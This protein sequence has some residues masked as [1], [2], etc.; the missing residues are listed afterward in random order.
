MS[1]YEI[2]REEYADGSEMYYPV[3][4]GYRMVN[5]LGFEMCNK[6]REVVEGW[7]AKFKKEESI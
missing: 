2:E 5:V 1:K 3:Q 4:N 6:R 7:V